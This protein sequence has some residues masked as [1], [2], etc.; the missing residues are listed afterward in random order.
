VTKRTKWFLG[1]LAAVAILGSA[2]GGGNGS[3]LI[4]LALFVLVAWLAWRGFVFLT[5]LLK[6]VREKIKPQVDAVNEHV[7][8]TLRRSGLS[9][10]V[11]AG[12]K[13]HAGLDGAVNETQRGI[14]D[15]NK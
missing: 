2:S 6:P 9:E 11:D 12:K 1:V 4:K 10:V 14:E 3:G 5:Q 15:R 7:D 8:D 13:F